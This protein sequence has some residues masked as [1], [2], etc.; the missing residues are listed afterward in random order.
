MYVSTALRHAASVAGAVAILGA[1]GAGASAADDYDVKVA[2]SVSTQGID[3]RQPAAAQKLYVRIQQAA[4]V[5]CTRGDRVNLKPVSDLNGCLESALGD[6][7]R[8]VHSPL[9]TEAYLQT[10]TLRQAAAHGIEPLQQ[11]AAK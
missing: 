2:I 11:V 10:H 1:F 3:L 9:L 7:I 8:K 5:A 6:A 4:Y